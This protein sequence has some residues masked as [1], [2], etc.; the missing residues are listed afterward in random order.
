MNPST[1]SIST[2]RMGK[3][4]CIKL[5]LVSG[6]VFE[7]DGGAVTI[8]EAREEFQGNEI[9]II[10]L[11]VSSPNS[12]NHIDKIDKQEDET[13][14]NYIG[15][16][17]VVL[18]EGIKRRTEKVMDELAEDFN[19][20]MRMKDHINDPENYDIWGERPKN[21]KEAWIGLRNELLEASNSDGYVDN[22][23]H[24]AHSWYHRMLSLEY[25]ALMR[26]KK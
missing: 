19:N 15:R 23:R 7:I 11:R 12:F 20:K 6:E 18:E 9:K 2:V 3:V 17:L 10:N 22:F 25:D 13:Q 14:S 1:R 8:E 4:K 21:L 5:E 24:F 26:E 16:L